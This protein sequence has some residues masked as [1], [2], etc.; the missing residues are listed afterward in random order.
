MTPT[1]RV[2]E[3]QE[4]LA[5]IPFQLGFQPRESVV[6]VSLREPRHRVG[7]VMRVDLADLA[8]PDD[9]RQLA[10][11]MVSHVAADGGHD[12]VLVVYTDAP[13][14]LARDGDSLAW[15]A[16]GHFLGAAETF[17]GSIDA[18]VVSETGYSVLGCSDPRCCPPGGR[19]LTDL[20][21]TI[22]GAEMVL[23]GAVVMETRDALAWIPRA[24]DLDRRRANAA[25]NRSRHQARDGDPAARDRWRQDGF[26]TWRAAL[27]GT[28]AAASL[29]RLEA[30][31]D[32]VLV[33]DAILLS[34]VPGVGDLP[35]RLL[36]G[37]DDLGRAGG[38][39]AQE[40]RRTDAAVGRAM[41]AIVDPRVGVPPEDD[42]SSAAQRTLEGI[43]AHGRRDRQAPAL[44]LLALLT[45]WRGSAARAG[46]LLERAQACDPRYRLAEL[47]S[48][49]LVSGMA[50]G[51]VR[52]PDS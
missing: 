37:S 28:L 8:Q 31:L 11:S 33:R 7:L 50:P 12:V 1:L 14:P 35:E 43:V 5:L 24:P 42:L 38:V 27:D 21:S 10:R 29:G 26:A 40:R 20:L 6:A 39:G 41:A 19:P 45:W 2:R 4:L 46:A 13:V 15:R 3:P 34:L 47:L 18:W 51:W 22:V 36:A 25:A 49:A 44:T 32:D 16:V 17:L 23:A 9:G 48:Q 30:A 52:R